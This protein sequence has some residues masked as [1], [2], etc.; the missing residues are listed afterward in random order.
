MWSFVVQNF[1]SSVYCRTRRN[2]AKQKLY[3]SPYITVLVKW[4]ST[5]YWHNITTTYSPYRKLY[6]SLFKLSFW[7][8]FNN[9]LIKNYGIIMNNISISYTYHTIGIL[10][11]LNLR[12]LTYT[13]KVLPRNYTYSYQTSSVPFFST[14]YNSLAYLSYLML[15][16]FYVPYPMWFSLRT[17]YIWI[18][19]ITNA[20]ITKNVFY[21]KI[22]RY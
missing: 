18:N 10:S 16:S 3:M 7:Q 12:P 5:R 11:C 22:Y 4:N 13:L 6:Y 20:D 19:Q 15:F 8:F 21:F 1:Y 9:I 14:T 17:R 2:V